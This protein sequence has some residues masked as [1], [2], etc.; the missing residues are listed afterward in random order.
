ML[1]VTEDGI[2]S[3]PVRELTEEEQDFI[4]ELFQEHADYERA[5]HHDK[6]SIYGS[7]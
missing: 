3:G 5:F 1:K 6:T 2:E 7:I 4:E